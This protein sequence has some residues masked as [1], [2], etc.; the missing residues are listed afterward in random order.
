MGS[1]SNPPQR[2]F[3][4]FQENSI[5]THQISLKQTAEKIAKLNQQKKDLDD[6]ISKLEETV[7][8]FGTQLTLVSCSTDRASTIYATLQMQNCSEEDYTVTEVYT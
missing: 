3:F 5:F 8:L 6:E 2:F 7:N 4:F 1:W